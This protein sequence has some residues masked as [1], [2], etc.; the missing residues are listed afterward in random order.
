MSYTTY[1]NNLTVLFQI[2]TG[3]SWDIAIHE[4]TGGKYVHTELL[5]PDGKQ[6]GIQ[7]GQEVRFID[8]SN[9]NY[10]QN[11]S[12]IWTQF[13]TKYISNDTILNWC[14]GQIGTKYSFTNAI[15]AGMNLPLLEPGYCCSQ[16]I[17]ITLS[18]A[19]ATGIPLDP[20]PSGTR[21]RQGLY[22]WLLEH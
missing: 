18:H 3:T 21:F 10:W 8:P 9:S 17:A 19:G 11:N 4:V 1:D 15:S 7:L 6:Y 22:E 13:P 12:K 5:F 14:Y 20:P 2:S 16:L